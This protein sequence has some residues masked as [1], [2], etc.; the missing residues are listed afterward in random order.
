M[1]FLS[2]FII[3]AQKRHN[4]FRLVSSGLVQTRPCSNLPNLSRAPSEYCVLNLRVICVP[5]I[6][7]KSFVKCPEMSKWESHLGLFNFSSLPKRSLLDPISN[8]HNK[9]TKY[10]EIS[11]VVVSSALH[12]LLRSINF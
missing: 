1:K 3:K 7:Q 6:S 2:S 11:S 12:P 9:R 4:I 8:S 10:S 5:S